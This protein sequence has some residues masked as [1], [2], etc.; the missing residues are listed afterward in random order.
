MADDFPTHPEAASEPPEHP[1]VLAAERFAHL[2]GVLLE[3]IKDEITKLRCDL[4]LA[5]GQTRSV[6]HRLTDLEERVSKIEE[7]E[8]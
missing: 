7:G 3:P 8:Q 1:A 4:G 5:N 6:L 2:V